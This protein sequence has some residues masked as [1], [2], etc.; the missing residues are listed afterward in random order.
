MKINFDRHWN[1]STIRN[2]VRN[3]CYLEFGKHENL[4]ALCINEEDIESDTRDWHEM[5]FVVPTK[6]LRKFCK[7]EFGVTNLDYWI[8]DVYTSDESEIIFAKALEERQ[9]VMIDF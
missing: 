9:V 8:S 3:N 2:M 4:K 6:W 1:E 7:K 5:A